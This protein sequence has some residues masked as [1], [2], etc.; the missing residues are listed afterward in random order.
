M[1][2]DITIPE[3]LNPKIFFFVP[4]TEIWPDNNDM[5]SALTEACNL[6][7]IA[8]ATFFF[9]FWVVKLLCSNLSDFSIQYCSYAFI[10]IKVHTAPASFSWICAKW[11][12]YHCWNMIPADKGNSRVCISFYNIILRISQLQM[13]W[14]PVA[15]LRLNN[16]LKNWKNPI[17]L[18]CSRSRR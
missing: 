4:K 16:R 12:K 11:K 5:Q 9:C 17:E 14:S 15:T 6:S 1:K 3:K 7:L 18:C 10:L 8:T 13:W 2:A